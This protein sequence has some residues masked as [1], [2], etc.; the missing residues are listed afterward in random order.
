[1]MAK[2]FRL[3]FILLAFGLILTAC[4]KT[5][6]HEATISVKASGNGPFF[7]GPNSL[8]ANYTVDLASLIEGQSFTAA[9]IKKVGVKAVN[10]SIPTTDSIGL[11]SFNNVGV[12]LVSDNA[13]MTN[14]AILN[15][16][17]TEGTAVVL[18]SSAEVDIADFFKQESFTILVD[19]D[20]KEDSWRA[21]LNSNVELQLNF[22][23]KK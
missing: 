17:N 7:A 11:D 6:E 23:I 5:E 18:N 22:K 12:Q 13:P 1:M 14:I 10:V 9:D 21:N 20:F 2:Y 15:P 4:G 16:I 19:W 8:M 3:G